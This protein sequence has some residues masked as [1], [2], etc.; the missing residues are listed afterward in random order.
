VSHIVIYR[1]TD[2]KSGYH[3]VEDLQKAVNYVEMLR[4]EQGVEDSR[5][6]R[7][8]QIAFRFETVYKVAVDGGETPPPPPPPTTSAWSAASSGLGSTP[9]GDPAPAAPAPAPAPSA[10]PDSAPTPVGATAVFTGSS[11][12]ASGAERPSE[13]SEVDATNGVRRGLFGR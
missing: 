1:S 11:E 6:Y 7:L 5:I 9:A 8:E 13:L 4:N 2:G 12:Q 3:Q 10:A